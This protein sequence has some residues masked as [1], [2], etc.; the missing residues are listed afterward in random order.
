MG[1]DTAE[2]AETVMTKKGRQFFFQEK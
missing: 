1:D 2:V